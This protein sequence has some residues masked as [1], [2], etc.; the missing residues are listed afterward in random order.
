MS[1]L[2]NELSNIDT[3]GS[4]DKSQIVGGIKDC[5]EK[6]GYTVNEL[7]DQKPW[8]AYLKFYDDEADS[9]VADLFPGLSSIDARLG[10]KKAE[11][12]P[13]ILIVSPDQRLSWQYHNRRAE[14][15][16]F[17]TDGL[18]NKSLTD[19]EQTVQAIKSGDVVQFAASER[20]RLIGRV[21]AYTL[22]AEIWQHTDSTNLSNE[23]DIVRLSDDYSR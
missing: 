5:A 1:E 4:V 18:Y 6:N 16:S 13:K 12:S 23:D 8:G 19:Q 2:F 22:V 15:W 21:A 17:L 11:L 3:S 10:N 20:H 14:R 7:N 9:F